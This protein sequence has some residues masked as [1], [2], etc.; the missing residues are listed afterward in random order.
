M[1]HQDRAIRLFVSYDLEHDHARVLPLLEQGIGGYRCSVC[2]PRPTRNHT[3]RPAR[4]HPQDDEPSTLRESTLTVVLIGRDTATSE[5]VLRDI[6]LSWALGK[7]LLGIHVHDLPD[8]HGRRSLFAGGNPFD[9]FVIDP[10][11]GGL[12]ETSGFCLAGQR[13]SERVPIFSWARDQG[14]LMARRWIEVAAGRSQPASE[15]SS[16]PDSNTAP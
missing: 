15:P 16:G 8:H 3:A 2:L 11:S 12:L 5:R 4:S 9:G 6:R 14:P 1:S 13:L 7:A 10:D